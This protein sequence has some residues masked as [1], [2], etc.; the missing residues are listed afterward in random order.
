MQGADVFD[1]ASE[2]D[3]LQRARTDRLVRH[4]QEAAAVERARE[5]GDDR[6]ELRVGSCLRDTGEQ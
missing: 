3:L 2:H 6:G 4:E 5:L 1:I